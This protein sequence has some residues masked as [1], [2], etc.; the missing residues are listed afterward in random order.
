MVAGI[1]AA[2]V[3]FAIDAVLQT[4]GSIPDD[5]LGTYHYAISITVL[6]INIVSLLEDLENI[7]ING[8]IYLFGFLFCTLL[9]K[10]FDFGASLGIAFAVCL[11]SAVIIW[12]FGN[13]S[14]SD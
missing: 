4:V 5:Q 10:G 11:I 8:P 1:V 3:G 7:A 14:F 6:V 9:L 13:A 12:Y 2:I